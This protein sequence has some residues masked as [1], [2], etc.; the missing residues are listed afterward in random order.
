MKSGTAI[1][2]STALHSPDSDAHAVIRMLRCAALL[3]LVA[4]GG[5][6]CVKHAITYDLT[7]VPRAQGGQLASTLDVE[8]LTDRRASEPQNR[9]LFENDASATVNGQDLCLNAESGYEPQ[10]VAHQ[11]SELIR[12][13]IE[14]R[15]RFQQVLMSQKEAA[16]YHLTGTL[17]SY[18]GSQA[19]SGPAKVGAMFGL[20]GALATM[21][22][23]TPGT[24]RIELTELQLARKDGSVVAR[25]PNVSEVVESDLSVDASCVAIYSNV[26]GRLPSAVEKLSRAVEHEVERAL[27]APPATAAR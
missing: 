26:D 17:R 1:M 23:T 19:Q 5:T 13:H 18:Y 11:I 14:K 9:I 24:I 3:A 4:T 12:A 20:V 2:I 15:G 7:T 21:N 10:T 25:L 22:L 27:A 6:G 8:V 16:D